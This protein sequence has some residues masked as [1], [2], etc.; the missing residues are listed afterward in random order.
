MTIDD[1][2][3]EVILIDDQLRGV[4][5]TRDRDRVFSCWKVKKRKVG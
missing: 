5:P 4:I 3:K 2:L 1:Q